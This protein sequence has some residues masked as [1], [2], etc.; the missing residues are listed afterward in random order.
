ML[1]PGRQAGVTLMELI[2][3]LA[4]AASLMAMAVPSFSNWLAG[5]R[6]RGSAESLLAGA[7]LARSE[8]VKRNAQVR[9]QLTS[10]ADNSCALSASGNNW[11]ISLDDPSGACA[12]APHATTAPRIIQ[13]RS[14]SEGT[15]TVVV[16]ATAGTTPASLLRFNGLG[17]VVAPSSGFAVRLSLPSAGSCRA[18]GGDLRCLEVRVSAAGQVKMCD[19]A[20][21]ASDPEGC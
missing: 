5:A 18:A 21:P 11:I 15:S 13:S 7:Q 3:A 8:A 19:P 1:I 2:I 9:F 10:T 20:L 12:A 17:Q 16:A 14:G 6:V 4:I